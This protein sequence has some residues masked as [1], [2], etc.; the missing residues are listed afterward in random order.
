MRIR[1]VFLLSTLL[2]SLIGIVAAILFAASQWSGLTREQL[3]LQDSKLLAESL[4]LPEALNFERAFINPLLVQPGAATAEQMGPVR[5]RVAEGDAALAAARSLASGAE[6]SQAL[7]RIQAAILRQRN[8]ALAAVAQP[9]EA[10]DAGL[11][12][13]YVPQMFA[14]QELAAAF[15]A[16][17]QRRIALADGR[18]GPSARLALMAW[19]MRDQAGRQ[20]TLTVRAAGLRLPMEGELAEQVALFRGRVD[21]AWSALRELA[22][23]VQSPAIEQAMAGVQAGYWSRGGD[24]YAR[25]VQPGRGQP[26][27]TTVEALFSDVIPVLNTITPLRDAALV[28]TLRRAE[29]AIDAARFNFV[30]ACLLAAATVLAS[31]VGAWLFNRRV[32]APAGQ[33]TLAVRALTGGAKEAAMPLQDRGDELGELAQAIDAMRRDAVAAE[34]DARA[35]LAEQQARAAR[36]AALEQ[37]ARAF[38]AEA[39]RALGAVTRA[40]GQLQDQARTLTGAATDG[41]GQADA[42]AGAAMTTSENVQLVAAAIEELTASIAEVHRRV[43]DAARIASGAA[44][45]ARD[46]NTA[47]TSL[48]DSSSR[49]GDVVRLISDIAGQTNLLAL[50]ATIE[51][52]RAGEAGKGFAVVAQEVKALASQTAKATEEISAQIGAMQG[53]T[54]GAV[55][56]IRAIGET[57]GQLEG[58]TVAVADTA[59]EQAEATR[60]IAEAISRAAT[61]AQDAAHHAEAVRQGAGRTRQT[62]DAVQGATG[63]LAKRGDE[64]Q[65]GVQ[66]FLT[67]L[68]AA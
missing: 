29:A 17:V 44:G 56:A 63:D 30:L 19:E 64:L 40:T 66:R 67:A 25:Y 38:E 48:A 36:G 33:L 39:D 57:V 60:S 45:A 12:R 35:S 49:I 13:D 18:L 68:R 65:D 10:R 46:G 59:R 61:G 43:A 26:P 42:V 4:R 2:G 22:L 31:L 20:V 6:D 3:A 21:A 8:A 51:A 53:A 1:Q 54:E 47:M 41:N 11:V 9:R 24:M 15:A 50:N 28:E 37:A 58:V 27:A 32:V 52:A 34:A 62:A 16:T 14:A 55:S 7:D 5:A 23:E